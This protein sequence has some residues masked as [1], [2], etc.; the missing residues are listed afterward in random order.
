MQN[1]SLNNFMKMPTSRCPHLKGAFLGE[2]VRV[3]ALRVLHPRLLPEPELRRHRRLSALLP[4]TGI[5]F[6]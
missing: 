5:T 2:A 1:L 3:L 4:H 6:Y